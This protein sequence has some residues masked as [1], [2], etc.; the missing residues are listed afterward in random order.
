MALDNEYIEE[1]DPGVKYKSI[2]DFRLII[3]TIKNKIE[4]TLS[5]NE[6]INYFKISINEAI[7]TITL[8]DHL[9][10]KIIKYVKELNDY[11]KRQSNKLPIEECKDIYNKIRVVRKH[12][13]I[14][15][16]LYTEVNN[17]LIS[18]ADLTNIDMKM[19]KCKDIVGQSTEDLGYI[20]PKELKETYTIIYD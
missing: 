13:N 10:P 4:V 8:L 7:T 14:L 11:Y 16:D 20:Y 18:K 15:V 12:H 17:V 3:A 5:E 1:I 19:E 9:L 6:P 2:K